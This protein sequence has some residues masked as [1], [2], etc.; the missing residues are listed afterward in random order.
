[1]H[2]RMVLLGLALSLY[3]IQPASAVTTDNF[4]SKT[5]ADMVALCTAREDDPQHA[6]A[7]AYC[8]GYLMG[9]Y[10]YFMAENSGPGQK[11]TVC[12]PEPQPTRQQGIAMFIDYTRQ[13]PQFMSERP[14]DTLTRFLEVTWPCA[15]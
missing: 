1:M 3:G 11:P 10:H 8:H 15:R 9:A 7:L 4:V 13:H 12:L 6:V 2:R 5:T 14:V